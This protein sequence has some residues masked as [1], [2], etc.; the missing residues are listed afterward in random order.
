MLGGEVG[1]VSAR[2]RGD[3]REERRRQEEGC[4]PLDEDEEGLVPQNGHD[5]GVALEAEKVE[6]ESVDD[7]VREG[8]LLVEEDTDEERV[9]A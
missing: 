3:E 9:G 1:L 8:V 4:V 5:A 2:S 7:L 6:D